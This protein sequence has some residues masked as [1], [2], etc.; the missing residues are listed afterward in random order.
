MTK[1]DWITKDALT[2]L[3]TKDGYLA[4][5]QTPEERIA[6]IRDYAYK[7][8]GDKERS[9]KFFEYVSR[10]YYVLSTPTWSNF[11]LSRGLSISCNGGFIDDTVSSI[12]FHNAET[13]MLTKHG[14]GTSGYYGKLRPMGAKISGGGAS[15]GPVHFMQLADLT[16]NIISQGAVRRGSYA[17]YLDVEHP[18][19]HEFIKIKDEGNAIQDMSIGV[20]ISDKWMKE[21]IDGDQ[22]K[23]ELWAEI[24]SKRTS[25]GYPYI[26]WSDTVNNNAPQVYQDK[27]K[28][29]YASNLCSEIALSSSEDETF[30]CNLLAINA[31][32]WRN[33]KKTDAI[34]IAIWFLDVV[35]SDYIEAIKDIPELKKAHKFATEQ[36]AIGL[37]LSG[38][39][40]LLMKE[41]IPFES[42]EAKFLNVEIFKTIEERAIRMS[43]QLAQELGEPELLK[44]YGMRNAT[45]MAVAPNTSSAFIHGVSQSIEPVH[46]HCM[47]DALAK[48]VFIKKT[49]ELV[50][51]LES[52]GKNTPEV[53]DS[54]SMHGGSVQHLPFLSTHEKEVFKTFREISQMEVIIQA[55][56]RQK[57]IDQSQSLNLWIEPDTDPK[58]VNRA[59]LFAWEN[60]IKTLYYVRSSS[61]VR[62]R[63]KTI[64]TC[65]SCEG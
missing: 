6:Q 19:I 41:M 10:N 20:C 2:F 25:K 47:A 64:M 24:L 18:D 28:R 14:A 1:F 35:M 7:I 48:G 5:N 45:L 26:F 32:E 63:N 46:G 36:R 21:M 13:G 33:I 52:K 38:W 40:T 42:M 30:V 39:H 55:A 53:W 44:G 65:T 34:E 31:A 54:I 16:T 59:T 12:L 56:Q 8:S 17:A 51:L 3:T 27:G 37:G 15:N 50:D 57:F 4:E 43:R 49:P 11:G 23:R 29:I 22:S 58:E 9:D 61:S 60:G 62:N